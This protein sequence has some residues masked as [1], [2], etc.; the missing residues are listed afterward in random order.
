MLHVCVQ[1]VCDVWEDSGSCWVSFRSEEFPLKGGNLLP[2]T[3]ICLLFFPPPL[4]VFLS[5]PRQSPTFFPLKGR[6]NILPYAQVKKQRE[7]EKDTA[8]RAERERARHV[9][10]DI[11]SSLHNA[12]D[13]FMADSREDLTRSP[14]TVSAATNKRFASCHD[15][16]QTV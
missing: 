2:G 16:S 10:D 1:C 11:T 5:S 4:H 12:L 6:E 3:I 9:F 14:L 8:V 15:V 7:R 13:C